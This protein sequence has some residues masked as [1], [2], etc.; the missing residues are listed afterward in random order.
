[1]EEERSG[2]SLTNQKQQDKKQFKLPENEIKELLNL[3]EITHES[4]YPDLFQ[5][6]WENGQH[7][8]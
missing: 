6:S 8:I 3:I 2:N 1:L 5:E 7:S 4:S